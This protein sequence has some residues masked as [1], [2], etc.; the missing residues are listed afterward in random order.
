MHD[1]VSERNERLRRIAVAPTIWFV[2]FLLCYGTV[3]V[4]CAKLAGRTGGLG[5]ARTAVAIYTVLALAGIAIVGWQG[6]RRHQFGMGDLPHDADTPEDRHRALGFATLLLS[7][8]SAVA[9]IYVALAAAFIG[10]CR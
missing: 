10:S 4:W 6:L 1:D 5:G 7:A 2:H 9:T 3:S 8:L